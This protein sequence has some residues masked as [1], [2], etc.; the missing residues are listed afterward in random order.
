MQDGV[1]GCIMH[2]KQKHD[3]KYHVSYKSEEN[4]PRF[5][6][7]QKFNFLHL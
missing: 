3:L 6:F 1:A 5:A 7:L 2:L 4:Y